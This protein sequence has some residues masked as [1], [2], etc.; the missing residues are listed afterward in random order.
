MLAVTELTGI[1]GVAV[2]PFGGMQHKAELVAECIAAGGSMRDA[3]NLVK[4]DIRTVRKLF[5]DGAFCD[6]LE[7]IRGL[8]RSQRF[9]KR[10]RHVATAF[11]VAQKAMRGE[12]DLSIEENRV[13]LEVARETLTETEHAI[14]NPERTID[15]IRRGR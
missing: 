2:V 3:A 4:V 5:D 7:Y 13:A 10:E 6:Y 1:G 12:L 14:Y 8:M 9:A 15:V 11:D